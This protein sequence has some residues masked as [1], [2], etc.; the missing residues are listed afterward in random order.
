MNEQL[1]ALIATIDERLAAHHEIVGY[2]GLNYATGLRDGAV[3]AYEK[4]RV[5]LVAINNARN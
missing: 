5:E 1:A 3:D 4:M 2:N